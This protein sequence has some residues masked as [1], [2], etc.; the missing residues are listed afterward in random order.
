MKKL[1][2]IAVILFL[3][4]SVFAQTPE[5]NR[6]RDV[7]PRLQ[8]S[9]PKLDCEDA[10]AEGMPLV[11]C[12]GENVR[13][14]LAPDTPLH[15]VLDSFLLTRGMNDATLTR[16]LV[17]QSAIES[18]YWGKYA[19]RETV[20]LTQITGHE[21]GVTKRAWLDIEP[22][23]VKLYVGPAD[24]IIFAIRD[25]KPIYLKPGIWDL[26]LDCS[27]KQIVTPDGQ[28]WTRKD[29]VERNVIENGKFG[30]E[31]QT[32]FTG[33]MFTGLSSFPGGPTV[34]AISQL[35]DLWKFITH[36]PNMTLPTGTDL[37]FH[38]NGIM[39][40]YVSP[41]APTGPATVTKKDP[42]GGQ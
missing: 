13:L 4:G 20:V 31:R 28:S 6:P 22:R 9:Q 17:L 15:L 36:R 27:I 18:E 2:V 7:R 3:T 42:I 11:R 29:D 21:S 8:S 10:E 12:A 33:D 39:A 23:R 25:K 32:Q 41:L 14:Q 16:T 34:Y 35:K 37:Y 40:T 38:I 24:Y 26:I 1:T 30:L 5:A 19:E